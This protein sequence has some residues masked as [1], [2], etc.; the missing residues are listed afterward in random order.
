[1]DAIIKVKS[2]D[3]LLGYIDSMIMTKNSMNAQRIDISGGNMVF[4]EQQNEILGAVYLDI[5]CVCGNYVAFKSGD[6]IPDKSVVC[7][8]C[9]NM[10]L[11]QY[12]GV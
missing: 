2:K 6:E 4:N 12:D 9:E 3:Y 11:L 8:L 1:M 10:Y 5:T 7:P